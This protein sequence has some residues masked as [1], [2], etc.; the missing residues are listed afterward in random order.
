MRSSLYVTDRTC[1]PV[2]CSLTRRSV[3]RMRDTRLCRQ[4]LTGAVSCSAARNYHHL[5]IEPDFRT[6]I[7]MKVAMRLH[8]YSYVKVRIHKT[9]ALYVCLSV[10]AYTRFLCLLVCVWVAMFIV[11]VRKCVMYVCVFVNLCVCVYEC[12]CAYVHACRCAYEHVCAW[13][14]VLSIRRRSISRSIYVMPAGKT[15]IIHVRR[16]ADQE[17]NVAR[18]HHSQ[19]VAAAENCQQ[20]ISLP[21]RRKLCQQQVY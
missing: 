21:V 1:F 8:A 6:I 9:F 20:A 19:L 14:C 16:C 15:V 18:L 13:M 3:M 12:R 11:Y 7:I 17:L 4:L 2:P 5:E 10:C